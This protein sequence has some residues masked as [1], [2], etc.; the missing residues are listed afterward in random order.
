MD[1]SQ[2]EALSWSYGWTSIS[3]A[4]PVAWVAADVTLKLEGDEQEITLVGFLTWVM[5][6]RGDQWLIVHGH[7]SFQSPE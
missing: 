4:G 1:F 2:W 7:V 6:N 3:A 5:E